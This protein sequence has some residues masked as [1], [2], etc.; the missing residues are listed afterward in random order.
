[1][2]KTKDKIILITGSTDGIGKQTAKDLAVTGAA[3]LI[4]G[5]DNKRT[6]NTAEEI[7][8]MTGNS[9]LDFFVADL[10]SLNEVKRLAEEIHS[11]YLHIDVLINNA[12]VFQRHKEM[13]SDGYEMTFAVNHLSHFLLTGLLTDLLEKAYRSRI[14][15][16][17]SI[18]HADHIDFE[19]LQGDKFYDGYEAY[20]LSKLCNIL[21]TYEAARRLQQSGI[22]VNCLHPGVIKT[23]LLRTG[24]G[25][26]GSPIET[27]SKTSV[28]LAASADVENVTGRYFSNL[29]QVASSKI[30]LDI[31]IQNKLWQL[32]EE[33]VHSFL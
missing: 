19:N 6:K 20:S 13:S 1:V 33:M 5:R 31:V 9:T 11:K 27:G 17:S 23:K 25:L 4:H 15:N 30:S 22:T 12:G 14:I 18:A 3:V 28:Y 26:G 7:A 10:S 21:F 24:W 16:V 2:N 8:E 32:S 29:R